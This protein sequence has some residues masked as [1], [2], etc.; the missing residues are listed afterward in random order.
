MK[1][2]RILL[3]VFVALMVVC[4]L[5][6][7]VSAQVIVANNV[8]Y[9]TNRFGANRCGFYGAG[10]QWTFYKVSTEVY[11]KTSAN[12]GQTWSSA[13]LVATGL[14]GTAGN[15]DVSVWN[16]GED[17][18]DYVS[19][20][21]ASATFSAARYKR[22]I[23][24][25]DG[26]IVWGTEYTVATVGTIYQIVN[27]SV[28][29]SGHP[30]IGLGQK[31]TGGSRAVV[32]KSS[33][34]DGSWVSDTG[35]PLS[36]G[37][38]APA[39]IP[40]ESCVFPVPLTGG[41]VAVV[42]SHGFGGY[43]G[44]TYSQIRVRG[45]TGN[46]FGADE[47]IGQASY[48]SRWTCV[49]Q[50]DDVHIIYLTDSGYDLYYNRY[51]YGSNPHFSG[52]ELLYSGTNNASKPTISRDSDT[53]NLWLW[54]ENDPSTNHIYL[55]SRN[56]DTGDWSGYYDWVTEADGITYAYSICS[57]YES[58]EQYIGYQYIAS[59]NIL[60]FKSLGT[61]LDVATLVPDP[62]GATTAT[63]RGEILSLGMGSATYRCFY[64]NDSPTLTGA[65][66]EGNETGAFS[67]GVFTHAVSGLT[68]GDKYYVIAYASN[69]YGEAY[70]WW[71]GFTAGGE[72]SD[73]VVIT[74]DPTNVKDTTATFNANLISAPGGC[75]MLGFEYGMT[76]TATWEITEGGNFSLG[77]FSID[78]TDL[79]ADSLYYVRA[80]AGNYTAED[81]GQWVGFITAQPS[82]ED[83]TADEIADSEILP[84]AP[85][86]P[87]G[88]IRPPKAWGN[89]VEG[90]P[91]T[92]VAWLGLTALITMV[93]LALTK[94]VKSLGVLFIVLGFILGV[95]SFWPKD[96]YLDWWVLFPYFLVGW[97]LLSRQ[98]ENPLNE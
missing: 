15:R 68:E 66:L 61:I 5:P 9:S 77:V 30:W 73:I 36:L 3:A 7:P 52:N 6:I 1:K 96:G 10:L 56:A 2:A 79:Q 29:S 13:T 74:L 71:Y 89:F 88:W 78:V 55:A 26:T 22:G 97:A 62:I 20:A 67:V 93:G 98:K 70:G 46:A 23:F 83:D 33:E 94:Y 90:I 38:Y 27:V 76:E 86:Q 63:L 69:D 41:K 48:L 60:K 58:P 59:T 4:L 16:H 81:H 14:D 49:G 75:T 42:W 11:Y 92:L 39:G 28:D 35:F 18:G 72:G 95:F 44:S 8:D 12:N 25:S 19:F 51:R 24:Y 53:D 43:G 57:N 31:G 64:I 80:I 50:D 34:T 37:Y 45:W 82:Y 84:P 32:T 21:Y 47:L 85:P 54:W 65:T 17:S 91:W 40:F 87:S